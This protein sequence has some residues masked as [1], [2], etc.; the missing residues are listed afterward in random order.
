MKNNIL[1][2]FSDTDL[3]EDYA[4][5]RFDGDKN[6]FIDSELA[7]EIVNNQRGEIYTIEDYVLAFNDEHIS[8]QGLI[9]IIKN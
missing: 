5:D 2:V 6:K 7:Y 1:Y 9:F 3:H 4:F 8:D